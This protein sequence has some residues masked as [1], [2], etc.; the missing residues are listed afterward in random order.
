M[1]KRAFLLNAVY[2]MWVSIGLISLLYLSL[3]VH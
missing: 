3:W 2:G 1:F